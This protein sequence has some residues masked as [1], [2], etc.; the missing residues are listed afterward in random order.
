MKENK[1]RQ[2]LMTSLRF[3]ELFYGVDIATFGGLYLFDQI[4]RPELDLATLATTI[5]IVGIGIL[6][7]ADSLR[8]FYPKKKKQAP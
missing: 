6:G 1:Q 4:S 7:A 8:Y 3:W 5:G 2:Q